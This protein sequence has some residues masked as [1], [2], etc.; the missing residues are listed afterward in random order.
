MSAEDVLV[1][2]FEE[3]R[4]SLRGFFIR[5]A[6]GEALAEDLLQ[7][8]VLRAWGHRGSLVG[9]PAAAE[10]VREG[11]RRYLWRV[12]RNLMID[13]IRW[14]QRRRAG[15]G[16]FQGIGDSLDDT[17]IEATGTRGPEEEIELADSLRVIREAVDHLENDRVR[18]CVQL[19]LGVRRSRD[20][21]TARPERRAGSGTA[22]AR[23]LG[24][25]STDGCRVCVS[26][27]PRGH[28]APDTGR[29]RKVPAGR[30]HH[31][32]LAARR[33]DVTWRRPPWR[34]RTSARP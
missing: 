33:R 7:E 14:R 26:R 10:E 15:E 12:A 6:G 30:R 21:A 11:A 8:T 27:A 13:E 25:H 16:S 22:P 24:D 18:R 1:T 2:A 23:T 9:D 28:H 19:W 5:G 20:R 17:M 31:R 34:T 4:P 29:A 32:A 3:Q